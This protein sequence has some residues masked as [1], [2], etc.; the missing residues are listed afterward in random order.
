MMDQFEV[1]TFQGVRYLTIVDLSR[2]DWLW[3]FRRIVKRNLPP[4]E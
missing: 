3:G 2:Y 1:I 4:S